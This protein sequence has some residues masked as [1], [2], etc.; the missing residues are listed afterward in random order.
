MLV[1]GLRPGAVLRAERTLVAA[2]GKGLNV[3][4][5]ARVLKVPALVCAPIGGFSGRM[6]A[7][8]AAAEGLA[9][10]WVPQEGGETRTCTLVV[11]PQNGD[12]TAL[13]ENGP[14]LSPADWQRFAVRA[15]DLAADADLVAVC[16]SLPP[17]VS[18]A[19]LADLLRAIAVRGRRLIVDTSGPALYAALDAEPY[20]VKV[21]AAELALVLDRPIAGSTDAVAALTELHRRGIALAAV[22]L[23]A[24]GALA[25]D[26]AVWYHAHPPA[27]EVVSSIGSG[28]AMLAGLAAGLLQNLDL[29]QTLQ[30]AVA[31]GSANARQFGGGSI[32]PTDLEIFRQATVVERI[33]V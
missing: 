16:G 18:P 14:T 30:L 29:P 19:A 7:E 32:D 5:V 2:G 24:A 23:G 6:L 20:A 8:L 27:I 12:A 26:G 10:D 13:N 17:G 11:D 9:G 25:G 4:R 3:A 15:V 22:T 33:I 1:S 28:D 21:N 31:C